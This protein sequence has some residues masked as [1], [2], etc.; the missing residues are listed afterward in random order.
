M[1]FTTIAK[2]NYSASDPHGKIQLWY[3]F[4]H[5]I[6]DSHHSE[7]KGLTKLVKILRTMM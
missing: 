4:H 2:V 6:G 3:I 5:R 1:P 7:G